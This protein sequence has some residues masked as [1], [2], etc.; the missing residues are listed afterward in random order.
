MEFDHQAIAI[1]QQTPWKSS[2][3]ANLS[4]RRTLRD[5][6]TLHTTA[7]NPGLIAAVLR[8]EAQQMQSAPQNFLNPS[9]PD[10]IFSPIFLWSSPG[11]THASVASSIAS[12][13][14]FFLQ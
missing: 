2:T 11:F 14:N 8:W 7:A 5:S 4:T 3:W 10:T 1:I 12:S 13:P 6:V 9:P